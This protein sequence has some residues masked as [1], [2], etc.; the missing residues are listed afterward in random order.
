MNDDKRNRITA[1]AS[2]YLSK[3]LL[4][5]PAEMINI[6]KQFQENELS[7][8]RPEHAE[9]TDYKIWTYENTPTL[10][11]EYWF[12]NRLQT[13]V[14]IT[15]MYHINHYFVEVDSLTLYDEN[16][17][18]DNGVDKNL[19]VSIE[20]EGADDSIETGSPLLREGFKFYTVESILEFIKMIYDMDP[21]GDE[22]DIY[23]LQSDPTKIYKVDY[24]D[25]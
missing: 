21:Y 18:E 25:D 11:V 5:G 20:Y 3:M 22:S 14:E 7:V 17:N 24:F 13:H 4:P 8:I 16:F 10:T 9:Q 12:E 15:M 2:K 19:F 1:A 23:S 6:L